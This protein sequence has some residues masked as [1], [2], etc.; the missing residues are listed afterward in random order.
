MEK[1]KNTID[2]VNEISK[3]Y[4][5]KSLILKFLFVFLIIGIFYSIITPNK[6]ESY[7]KFYPHYENNNGLN[8]NFQSLANL[9][10]I[11]LSN[12]ISNNVPSTLYPELIKSTNF[13]KEILFSKVM[14]EN[15]EITYGEYLLND[16]NKL[17]IK[18]ILSFPIVLISK[19]FIKIE[20]E[21]KLDYLNYI[22]P[23]ENKLYKLL[24]EK[25]YLEIN[26]N[27]GFIKLTVYDKEPE[28]SARVASLANDILQKNIINFKLKNIN[29][30]YNFTA[31]QLMEAKN[32]FYKIQDSLAIFRDSNMSIKSD[33][34]RNKL[35]RLE[36]EK[37]VLQNV[38]N[39]LAIT[40]ERIAIDVKKNTPIFTI[41]NSVYV[42]IDKYSPSRIIII[43]IFSM[44][45]FIIG[46]SWILLKK[47][48]RDI[49][50]EIK[51]KN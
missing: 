47:N 29:E 51:N 50:N 22:S 21:K 45:G 7:T 28:I 23:E 32:N 2:L 20:E 13:K 33:I 44:T 36:T 6:Y 5:H 30:V 24:E 4:T 46:T 40:K 10:G 34:F 18:K 49:I 37:N 8:Q 9:A 41:I 39:E 35:S 26:K 43:I 42:P 25:I 16:L 12:D 48:I 38:Y 19:V 14:F 15:N 1:N 11:D 27:S 31:N 17:S 3:L